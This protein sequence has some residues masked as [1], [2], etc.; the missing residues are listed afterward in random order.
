MKKVF[1]LIFI[2]HFFCPLHLKGQNISLFEQINGRYDFT[3]IGNTMNSAEN[4]PT[5]FFVTTTTSSATLNLG[6]NDTIIRA[7]LYW[8]EVEMGILM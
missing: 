8:A 2:V 5:N 4:N 3:F 7:Y 6:P 1:F